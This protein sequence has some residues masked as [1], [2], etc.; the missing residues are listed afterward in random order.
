MTQSLSQLKTYSKVSFEC[1]K[2]NSVFAEYILNLREMERIVECNIRV[3]P[4]GK[5]VNKYIE[6][7]HYMFIKLILY[8]IFKKMTF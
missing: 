4:E 6:R 5:S 2:V 3:G 7:K 8:E 1:F